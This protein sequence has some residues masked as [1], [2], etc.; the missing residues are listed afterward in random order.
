MSAINIAVK[1]F[2]LSSAAWLSG[3]IS[4]LSM[5][6]V[7]AVAN[8][9]ADSKL[10]NGH[11]VRIWEQNFSL[12]KTQNPPIALA[13]AGSLAFLAWSSRS[14]RTVTAVG[15]RSSPL[16][17]VAAVTTIGIV[18]YTIAFMTTTNNQLLAY[19]EKAKKDDLSVTET[20]DVDVL[21]QRWTSLNR[22]RGLLPLAGAVAAGLAV[23]A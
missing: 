8:I 4:A 5:V 19:A 13:S 10:S 2:G 1:I 14:L 7:P 16:F 11:A 20:E 15:L 23:I 21:L 9:K 22:V 6:S 17:A 12:G 18:P 3:N